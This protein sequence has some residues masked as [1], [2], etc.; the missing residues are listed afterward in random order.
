VTSA[1]VPDVFLYSSLKKLSH[2]AASTSCK[3][4]REKQL[5]IAASGF[6]WLWKKKEISLGP[7]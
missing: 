5:V 1:L 6:V 7:L 4:A 2:E 3:A